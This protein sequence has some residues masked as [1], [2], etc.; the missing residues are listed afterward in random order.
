VDQLSWSGE[1]LQGRYR[2]DFPERIT[3]DPLPPSLVWEEHQQYSRSPH[4][5]N[6]SPPSQRLGALD[7]LI[8]RRN[9]EIITG[10]TCSS[11][12]RGPVSPLASF[13]PNTILSALFPFYVVFPTVALPHP[14]TAPAPPLD[15]CTLTRTWIASLCIRH[16]HA[17]DGFYASCDFHAR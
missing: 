3:V 11:W 2:S 5:F 16:M 12:T 13:V 14:Q 6:Q 1:F 4:W 17:L 8:R 15:C 10:L 9:M 7:H